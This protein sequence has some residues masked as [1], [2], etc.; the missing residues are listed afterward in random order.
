MRQE[1]RPDVSIEADD[2]WEVVTVG[3]EAAKFI[4]Q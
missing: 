3:D 4:K 1:T 2:L